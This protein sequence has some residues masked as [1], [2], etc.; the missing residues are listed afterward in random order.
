MEEPGERGPLSFPELLAA[1]KALK[2]TAAGLVERPAGVS[3]ATWDRAVELADRLT[4]AFCWVLGHL[5]GP[6]GR[7]LDLIVRAAGPTC[8][9]LPDGG[10]EGYPPVYHTVL[11]PAGAC[12]L[13]GIGHNPQLPHDMTPL[14]QQWFF[15]QR[16]RRA[17]LAD[18]C[19]HCA[20]PIQG[21]YAAFWSGIG[22]PWPHLPSGF[23]PPHWFGA[24]LQA[25]FAECGKY[26]TPK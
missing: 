1:H 8:G 4:P 13:C 14:F 23:T 11:P 22:V 10:L 2:M 21:L 16:G 15:S 18:A 12:A 3:R 25:M 17:T 20:E 19:A 24:Q 9:G 7:L 26:L 6:G 5:G